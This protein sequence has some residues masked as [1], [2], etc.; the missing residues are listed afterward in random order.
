[1][2]EEQQDEFRDVLTRFTRIYSFLSQIVSFGDSDLERDYLFGK[3]LAAFIKADPGE[4]VDLSGAVE[5]HE[6]D[7]GL[8]VRLP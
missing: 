8:P 6:R 2:S 3:A 7:V 5:L 1:M 4:T